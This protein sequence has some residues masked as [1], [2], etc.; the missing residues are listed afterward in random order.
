M[1]AGIAKS[2]AL[3]EDGVGSP[4]KRDGGKLSMM[5]AVIFTGHMIDLPGR[6]VPRFPPALETAATAAIRAALVAA[7]AHMSGEKVGYASAARGG[8][9]LFHEQARSLGFRTVIV[10]PF[11]PALFETTSVAGATG[12]N[13]VERFRALWA[14]DPRDCINLNLPRSSEAYAACNTRMIELARAHGAYHLI[15][16]W[17]GKGGDGPG[18]SADLV[19]KAE[20]DGDKPHIIRPADLR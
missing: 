3:P 16:L 5:D 2:A 17:D 14:A 4:A 12:G 1:R 6:A 11:A 8:D 9:I 13:W 15:A 10:L 20:T 7:M 19:R 18:G